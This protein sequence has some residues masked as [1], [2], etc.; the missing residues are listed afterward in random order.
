MTAEVVSVGTELLL[1]QTVD[2]HAS[3]IARV[4][5]DCGISCL[6]RTT[7]GDNLGRV[8]AVLRGSLERADIVVTIGGLGPTQ[9]DVTREAVAAALEDELEHVPE[10]EERL[11]KMT[12]LRKLPWIESLAKQADKPKC[13]RFLPN[14]NGS[15]PGLACEK[16]GKR[17]LSLPGPKNEFNPM[18]DGP[19]REYLES[20]Q[21]GQVIHSRI[22]RVCGMGESQVEERI[23]TLLDGEN[24]TVA[25]YAHPGEV[26]LR[27]TARATS[28]LEADRLID[29]VHEKIRAI[30]GDALFGT[31][32]TTLEE[33][34]IELLRR[35]AR[36]VAVA[37]SITGGGL[38]ERLTSVPGSS[39][40]FFGGVIAYR[41]EAK[42]A[43]LGIGSALLQQHGPV[44]EAVAGAMAQSIRDK[45]GTDFGVSITGNA[46]P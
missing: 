12:A 1:G 17:I 28:R 45:L 7:V 10:Y 37:E 21:G 25:P 41:L 34:T 42:A 18:A 13:G 39:E 35:S 22:L 29:P 40:V 19:V 15:A 9:D 5:A 26:H 2:T 32:S 31:D 3:T 43:L 4:L 46:G 36:S 38:G 30:L 6:R 23:A 14:P 20:L 8:V 33:A 44:S 27:L 11:R 16:N 24:P